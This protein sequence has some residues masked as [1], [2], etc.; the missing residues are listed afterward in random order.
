MTTIEAGRRIGINP[1]VVARYC[2]QGKIKATFIPKGRTQREWDI[3]ESALTRYLATRTE[4]T[5]SSRATEMW[6]KRK[7]IT[8]D[9]GHKM[10]GPLPTDDDIEDHMIR[11]AALDGDPV[12]IET[13]AT[14]RVRWWWTHTKGV[15][16]GS[17]D[18]DDIRA[19]ADRLWA[20]RP[21]PE[22]VPAYVPGEE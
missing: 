11:V 20:R 6:A 7:Q 13:L 17:I 1:I 16:M 3:S 4:S 8:F 2:R 22:L 14:R 19:Y 21:A 15:V 12:A 5:R 18:L 9:R 10:N